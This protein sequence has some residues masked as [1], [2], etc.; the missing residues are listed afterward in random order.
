MK[1][2]KTSLVSSAFLVGLLIAGCNTTPA[3]G[4]AGTARTS[5]ATGRLGPST[6]IG[7]EIG[8][9]I[10]RDEIKRCHVRV[11]SITI[12]MGVASETNAECSMALPPVIWA[13]A[14]AAL[15]V[16]RKPLNIPVECEERSVRRNHGAMRRQQRES[17]NV[18]PTQH[19]F[20]LCFRRQADNPAPAAE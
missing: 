1:L 8:T 3:A 18:A 13:G 11:G 12:R 14:K 5:G 9:R 6:E 7:I 17:H 4:P 19:D 15:P 20:R 10:R 16:Q 2:L